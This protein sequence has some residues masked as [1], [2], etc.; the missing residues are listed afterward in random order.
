VTFHSEHVTQSI[1]IVQFQIIC[2]P[3]I[4]SRAGEYHDDE[5]IASIMN[6][7]ICNETFQGWNWEDTCR[8]VADAGYS[9][10][11]VAPFTLAEDVRSV[12]LQS[13]DDCAKTAA[14]VGLEVVGLHWLLI[15]PKGLSLTTTDEA[16]RRE[17]SDYLAA[18]VDFCADIGGKVMVL[19][20]PAQ[21]RLPPISGSDSA[22]AYELA[23]TWLGQC[24]EPAL[25]RAQ[26]RDVKLCLEPLPAPEAN[27]IQTLQEAVSLLKRY[28]HPN[29]RT[30]FDVKSASSEGIPLPD[31]I[32]EF[33]PH[34]AHV[35]AND[36]NRRG[37]G[38]GE[39]DFKP[40]FSALHEA[41]Y[42]GY[43]SVEVFDYSP[44]PITIARE[45]LRYMRA[46]EPEHAD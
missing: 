25:H 27:F 18:L 28:Q 24:L 35:H 33:A 44:D 9:G 20:S 21:R 12:S 13:R 22:S 32:R 30:M 31:L 19:G 41:D 38:F 40:V 17:T 16:V 45:S 8:A 3:E 42:Q 23:A 26:R 2:R 5:E 37:P 4:R 7:A 34:I 29:L 14:S 36:A 11:E 39:T 6:Y 10:I 46:C 1:P 43:T 15:S